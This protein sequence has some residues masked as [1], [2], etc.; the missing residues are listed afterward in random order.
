MLD[1]ATAADYAKEL[2]DP[3]IAQ[4][5]VFEDDRAKRASAVPDLSFR[6]IFL[7]YSVCKSVYPSVATDP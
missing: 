7:P 2:V 6:I 4:E 3:R 1:K 5:I